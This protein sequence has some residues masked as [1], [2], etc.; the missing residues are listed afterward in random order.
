M[1]KNGLKNIFTVLFIT[2][3]ILLGCST[4][5]TAEVIE[6]QKV[7]TVKV[8]AKSKSKPQS[9]RSHISAAAL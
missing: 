4:V 1:N 8:K 3:V 5:H 2:L 6:T 7:A 9:I